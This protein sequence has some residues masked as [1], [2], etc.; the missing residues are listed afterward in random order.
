MQKYT[1]TLNI[2]YFTIKNNSKAIFLIFLIKKL[3]T[4]NDNWVAK[5]IVLVLHYLILINIEYF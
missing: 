1:I 5:T 4:I 3:N 2:Q